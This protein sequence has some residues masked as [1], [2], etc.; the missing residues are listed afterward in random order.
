MN[1]DPTKTV[2]I[3]A[4]AILLTSVSAVHTLESNECGYEVDI[5]SS[6]TLSDHEVDYVLKRNIFNCEGPD[7][8]DLV[9][10]DHSGFEKDLIRKV[11]GVP[12]DYLSIQGCRIVVNGKAVKKDGGELFCVAGKRKQLLSLYKGNL[13]GYLLLS[14]ENGSL[15]STR[16][17]IVDRSTLKGTVVEKKTLWDKIA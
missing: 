15:D 1:L 7:K 16:F 6:D 14:S 2:S 13:S 9:M 3:L 8:G 12:G 5:N 11:E 4:I 10:F 17:G